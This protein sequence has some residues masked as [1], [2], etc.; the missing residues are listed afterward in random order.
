MSLEKSD[1]AY[2]YYFS[3]VETIIRQRKLH[4]A[5]LAR[6]V[7]VIENYQRQV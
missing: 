7:Q 2:T 4:L 6:H 5:A 1:L 3:L